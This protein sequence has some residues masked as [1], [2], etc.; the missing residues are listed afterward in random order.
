MSDEPVVEHP[1]EEPPDRYVTD[2]VDPE[3]DDDDDEA[4]D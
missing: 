3:Q 1:T 2:P 4:D